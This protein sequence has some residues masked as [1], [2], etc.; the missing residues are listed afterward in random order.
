LVAAAQAAARSKDTY[1]AAQYP[2]IGARQEAKRAAAA[3]AYTLLLIIYQLLTQPEASYEDLGAVYF[4]RRDGEPIERRMIQR[5]R[6]WATRRH[7]PPLP[8]LYLLEAGESPFP[9]DL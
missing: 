2:W 3:V 7:T 8:R 4:D 5:W 6:P 1:L 9:P